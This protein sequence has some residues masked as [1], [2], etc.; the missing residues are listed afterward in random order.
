M[1]EDLYHHF[2]DEFMMGD[3]LPA[4]DRQ[5]ARDIF[6]RTLLRELIKDPLAPYTH[7]KS[8]K[9]LNDRT[10]VA[11]PHPLLCPSLLVPIARVLYM[12]PINALT[13]AQLFRLAE[14]SCVYQ[15]TR[16]T[17]LTFLVSL[18]RGVYAPNPTSDPTI[19]KFIQALRVCC[20]EVRMT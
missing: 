18:L 2:G 5:H 4:S 12:A 7:L 1:E 9:E 17:L 19:L 3:E 14:S 13:N 11:F 6:R 16:H 20:W 8:S 10:S 15:S